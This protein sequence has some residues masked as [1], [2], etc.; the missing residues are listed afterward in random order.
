[1]LLLAWPCH[2]NFALWW[3][4]EARFAWYHPLQ[5]SE[6]NFRAGRKKKVLDIFGAWIPSDH[7]A[8]SETETLPS[9]MQPASKVLSWD[10]EPEQDDSESGGVQIPFAVF[11]QIVDIHCI[12]VTG[13]SLSQTKRGNLYRTHRMMMPLG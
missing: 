2:Q 9:V 11:D 1:M 3:L 8:L 12:D 7:L 10:F 13:L 5:S 6:R 4:L